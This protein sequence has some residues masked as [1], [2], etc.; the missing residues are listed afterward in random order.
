[1]SL[2]VWPRSV[3]QLTGEIENNGIRLIQGA[4]VWLEEES[5]PMF[6]SVD[7][8]GAFAINGEHVV[9]LGNYYRIVLSDGRSGEILITK[10]TTGS[11]RNVARFIG[12]G[13]LQHRT[14]EK[15]AMAT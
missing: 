15:E 11:Y 7:W 14:E 2:I 5:N 9:H 10:I 8:Y 12:R 1:M 4:E 3:A 13:P 6:N